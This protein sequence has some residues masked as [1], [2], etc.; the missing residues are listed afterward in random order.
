MN[1]FVI[2]GILVVILAVAAWR[3]SKAGF[4]RSLVNL[5][6]FIIAT[7]AASASYLSIADLLKLVFALPQIILHLI[8]F[9]LVWFLVD[10]V[11]W[12]ILHF[13]R[14]RGLYMPASAAGWPSRLGGAVLGSLQ[15]GVI[16][17]FG[18]IVLLAVP[19]SANLKDELSTAPLSRQLVALGSRYQQSVNNAVADLSETLNFLTVKPK[20]ETSIQLGFKTANVTVDPATEQAMIQLVNHERTSRGLKA[21]TVD[22]KLTAVA[23][24]HSQDML[25]RGYFSHFSPEHKD[26]SDRLRAGGV[27]FVVYGEN[28][29]LAPTLS[30]AHNGLMNSPEHKANILEP[31]FRRIGIGVYDAGY[32]GKMFTQDFAD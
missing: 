25:A 18:L 2:S 20:S 31:S 26:P 13:V 8:A 29:A 10:I 22:P 27:K 21:L 15:A 6:G 19:V 3:G 23:R 9:I 17:T 16:T 12:L 28:L 11:Y 7:A 1:N 32:F 24:A 5:I 30:L 4:G 14:M